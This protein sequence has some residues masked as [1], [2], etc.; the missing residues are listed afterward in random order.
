MKIHRL[1][2]WRVTPR[3][4]IRIQEQIQKEVVARGRV[5]APILVAGADATFDMARRRVCAAVVVLSFPALKPV[6]TV[7]HGERLSFPYIP[8]L[9]AFREAPALLHAFEKV[10][11]NPDLVFIDGHGLSHPRAAGIACHIG[12]LLDRLVIGCA[13]SLL[14]G[15]YQDPAA[16]RGASAPYIARQV[17]S[18]PRL[19]GHA[20]TYG[21]CLF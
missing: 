19:F 7:I 9:L 16:L 6:E 12:L 10:R 11:C 17:T 8:G 14:P 18:S 2:C 3:D 20:I 5:R 13:K 1:H 4:A 21:R 15:T